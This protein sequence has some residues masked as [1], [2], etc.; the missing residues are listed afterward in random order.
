VVR[1]LAGH[2]VVGDPSKFPVNDRDDL[3]QGRVLAPPPGLEKRC[4][5]VGF[6]LRHE[7]YASGTSDSEVGRIITQPAPKKIFSGILIFALI[8]R[9]YQ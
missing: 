4:H 9:L 7:H 6:G 8:S 5:L 1:A 2:I 3:V